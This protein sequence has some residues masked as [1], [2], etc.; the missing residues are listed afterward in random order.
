MLESWLVA[1][2]YKVAH[3]DPKYFLLK[4]SMDLYQAP[5]AI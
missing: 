2:R 1:E 3:T 5:H 4:M